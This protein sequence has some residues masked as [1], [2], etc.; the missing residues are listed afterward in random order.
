MFLFTHLC[1][2]LGYA[3]VIPVAQEIE[4]RDEGEDDYAYDNVYGDLLNDATVM[5]LTLDEEP[6]MSGPIKIATS[7]ADA[8]KF[9]YYEES[10]ELNAAFGHKLTR[11]DWMSICGIVETYQKMLFSAPL[12]CVNVE[13][14]LLMEMKSE[15]E[16]EGRV[17]SFLCG[18][19]ANIAGVLAALNAED[20]ALPNTLEPG[21]PIGGKL[22]FER[23]LD[24][25]GKAWYAVSIIY[26]STEQ[27]RGC[28]FLSLENPPMKGEIRFNEMETNADGLIA[29]EDLLNRFQTAID[30][31]D[32]LVEDYAEEEKAA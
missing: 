8:L 29:E 4:Q 21:T 10:D 20:Y 17:F 11:E 28:E 32:N 23:Y 1:D 16:K 27:V 3:S 5:S 6:A 9:Q 25:D 7:V 22:T 18:H 19:D 24:A 13:H 15:L 14:P 12:I 26:Q 30:A 31:F 2:P